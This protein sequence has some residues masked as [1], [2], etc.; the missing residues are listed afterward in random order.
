PASGDGLIFFASEGALIALRDSDGAV[1][2]RVP[3]S[4]SL[5]APLVWD[6]GWL[7]AAATSNAVLVFR[8]G[9]GELIWQRDVGSPA[10]VQPA[11]AADRV[12]VATVDQRIIA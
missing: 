1:Q 6:N 5:A 7:I 2:W 3:F 9:D 8:A 4:G 10:S 11:L 12:Y